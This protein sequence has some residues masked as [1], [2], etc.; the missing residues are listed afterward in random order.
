MIKKHHTTIVLMMLFFT[1]LI[2]LWWADYTGLPTE[3]TSNRVLPELAQRLPKDVQRIE[4]VVADPPRTLVLERRRGN[5]WQMTRPLDVAAN[6]ALANTL[7]RNLIE[8]RRSPESGTIEGPAG[9][10]GLDAPAATIKVFG[11]DPKAPL[12]G[13]ELGSALSGFKDLRYARPLGGKGIEVVDARMVHPAELDATAWRE[14]S[15]FDMPTFYVAGLTVGGPGRALEAKRE[16][17]HWQLVRP[18]SAPADDEKVEEVVAELSSMHVA[19]DARGYVADDVR[20]FAPY[21]LDKPEMTIELASGSNRAG[22][23]RSRSAR[24]SPTGPTSPTPDAPS[25]TT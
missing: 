6:S 9:S 16:E 20:D 25:R 22:P 4:I 19:D 13:L 1:G 7:A 17:G 8:L 18:V 24:P 2:V 10:Y 23:R 11:A 15:V 12:A 3:A 5:D 14:K 21:G